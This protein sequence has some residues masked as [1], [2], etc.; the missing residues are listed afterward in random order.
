MLQWWR[1]K[2]IAP[3]DS[4]DGFRCDRWC[5]LVQVLPGRSKDTRYPNSWWQSVFTDQFRLRLT[6][7]EK[8]FRSSGFPRESQT[9]PTVVDQQRCTPITRKSN[10]I[11]H[12][13]ITWFYSS[14]RKSNS[15]SPCFIC[16]MSLMPTAHISTVVMV[17]LIGRMATY[18]TGHHPGPSS[19]WQ[20]LTQRWEEYNEWSEKPMILSI[21]LSNLPNMPKRSATASGQSY[22]AYDS[23]AE[24]T[25]GE[26]SR[27]EA[28][29]ALR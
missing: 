17:A 24:R 22:D 9:R 27:G 28:F 25:N 23:T 11:L 21:L 16:G 5:K 2:Y 1:L 13:C 18:F 7:R 8:A 26:H 4:G 10:I 20:L 15:G 29:L 3:R 12:Q 6:L 14:P 19:Y